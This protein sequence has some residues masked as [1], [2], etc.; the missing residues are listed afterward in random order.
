[1]QSAARG[2]QLTGHLFPAS[3]F[4]LSHRLTAASNNVPQWQHLHEPP[5]AHTRLVGSSPGP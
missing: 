3:P 4:P 2:Q 1:M 5:P